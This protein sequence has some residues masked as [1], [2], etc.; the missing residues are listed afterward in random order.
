MIEYIC[1]LCEKEITTHYFNYFYRYN[2]NRL[3]NALIFKFKV[4]F[5]LPYRHFMHIMIW[6]HID[7]RLL[8]RLCQ[9]STCEDTM[10][11]FYSMDRTWYFMAIN[12]KHFFLHINKLI[13]TIKL[14]RP[15]TSSSEFYS[16]VHCFA[17]VVLTRPIYFYR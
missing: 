17:V 16:P 15:L 2:K 13:Q 5:F 11:L 7:I 8:F 4:Y 10:Y 14:K 6:R 12:V 1:C 9:I 3:K